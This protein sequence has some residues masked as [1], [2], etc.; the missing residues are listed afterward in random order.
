MK[1]NQIQVQEP[2]NSEYPAYTS[3]KTNNLPFYEDLHFM[4]RQ[5]P[6]KMKVS[7]KAVT[8]DIGLL[9]K[10]AISIQTNFN[11]FRTV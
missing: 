1:N 3:K 10:K 11:K 7:G 6:E 2:L 8:N 5:L 9:L 4:W